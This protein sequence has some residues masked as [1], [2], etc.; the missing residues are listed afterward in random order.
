[1]EFIDGKVAHETQYFSEPFEPKKTKS[2]PL[3]LADAGH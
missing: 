3:I 1:M 2:E